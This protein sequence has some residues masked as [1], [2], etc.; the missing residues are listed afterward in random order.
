MISRLQRQA[1]LLHVVRMP[2]VVEDLGPRPFAHL[3]AA[4]HHV[5]EVHRLVR[6]PDD[7]PLVTFHRRRL[8]HA[9]RVERELL[10]SV[11]SDAGRERITGAKQRERVSFVEELVVLFRVVTVLFVHSRT[12]HKAHDGHER[13]E[14]LVS[15]TLDGRMNSP[16]PPPV[17]LMPCGNC[18]S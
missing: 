11:D 16:A 14:K 4:C 10:R 3:P 5:E 8:Q 9:H 12:V 18:P 7:G 15:T 1:H 6:F 13:G 17:L 2:L